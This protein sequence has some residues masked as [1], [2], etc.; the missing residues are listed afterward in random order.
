MPE[1]A[2][3][4]AVRARLPARTRRSPYFA[5]VPDTVRSVAASR[6]EG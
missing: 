4:G 5:T 1:R 6:H 3:D 2:P